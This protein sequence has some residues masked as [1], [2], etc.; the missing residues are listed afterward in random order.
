MGQYRQ[1]RVFLS[2]TFRD[3]NEERDYLQ[4]FIFPSL[5][6]YC[7]K[8]FLEFVPIDLRW[9]IK[10]ESSKGLVLNTCLQEIDNSRPFFV[11]ILGSR[12]GW[13][14]EVSELK[15]ISSLRSN[16]YNWLDSMINEYTSITEM[17]F[18]YGVLRDMN[19]PHACFMLRSQ[20]VDI[21]DEYKESPN[22]L[23]AYKLDQLK[24]KVKKQS[25]Y[26]VYEYHSVEE[27]AKILYDEIISMIDLEYPLAANSM[28]NIEILKHEHSLDSRA[29]TLYDLSPLRKRIDDWM[30]SNKR[31]FVLTGW[32]GQHVSRL[33]EHQG[34]GTSTALAYI[35]KSVRQS[36]ASK[37]IY[38]DFEMTAT[39]EGPIDNFLKFMSL[40]E[41]QLDPQQYNL[42]AL[43]N[44]IY[45]N[46]QESKQLVDWISHTSPY[47]YIIVTTSRCYF[48]F[49]LTSC[50]DWSYN[51]ELYIL[52]ELSSS[53][54]KEFIINYLKK[55]GKQ[56]TDSQMSLLLEEDQLKNP[57]NLKFVLDTLIQFGRMELL[58][59]RLDALVKHSAGGVLYNYLMDDIIKLQDINLGREYMDVLVAIYLV[60]LGISENEIMLSLNISQTVWSILRSFIIPLC[61]G[62]QNRLILRQEHL[63]TDA[64]EIIER[65]Y[66]AEHEKLH[67]GGKRV[68]RQEHIGWK[69]TNWFMHN[70]SPSRIAKVVCEIWTNYQTSIAQLDELT[71]VLFSI[72][73]SP[74]CIL[75]YLD[76]NYISKIWQRYLRS[77]SIAQTPKQW[78]GRSMNDLTTD[79][80][81]KYYNILTDVFRSLCRC[82]DASDC[83]KQIAQLKQS[84]QH[85]DAI[86]YEC[87]SLLMIGQAKECI[88]LLT[89]SN[90]LP[91]KKT[92]FSSLIHKRTQK[93]QQVSIQLQL[94]AIRLLADAYDLLG[95]GSKYYS[96][97]E[98]FDHIKDT[99]TIDDEYMADLY[100]EHTLRCC[101]H[102]IVL[103]GRQGLLVAE[104]LYKQY[105][106]LIKLDEYIKGGHPLYYLL[107]LIKALLWGGAHKY[108]NMYATAIRAENKAIYQFGSSSYQRMQ[109]QVLVN[110]ACFK[111]KGHFLN[112]FCQN[113]YRPCNFIRFIESTQKDIAW[114]LVDVDVKGR[115][116]A[117]HNFFG[118]LITSVQDGNEQMRM[119]EEYQTLKKRMQL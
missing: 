17:E 97:L 31:L 66:Y 15:S 20:D 46:Q 6:Q 64:R 13:I 19:I 2:S 44:V 100:I 114:T 35:I 74:D 3:M 80:K 117:E 59:E 54:Q 21:P 41:N 30:H 87:K 12:Y 91:P 48:H 112:G 40:D 57:T 22:S 39:D 119:E 81:I 53:N 107:N 88:K 109:A 36:Y 58:D 55:Y 98:L 42:I 67:K 9:G 102:N 104:E 116:L 118:P 71:E 94:E 111:F 83:S 50:S 29:T 85:E 16:D 93:N 62:N 52:R 77:Y 45:L 32:N 65:F 95:K 89:Q 63:G 25:Q 1:V 11:G 113:V 75:Y 18:E 115:I 47:T 24:K 76:I 79:E 49:I 37:I 14:P 34:L 51:H 70:A 60:K 26:S 72:G 92:F 68:L 110:Y 99:N 78:I 5:R 43:D 96:C 27:F 7:A 101:Y 8:R 108:E 106:N 10:E 86:L 73:I 61:Q 33:E 23:E 84:L 56:L 103:C 69:L 90:L 38:Y 28:S 82:K 105:D 4:D